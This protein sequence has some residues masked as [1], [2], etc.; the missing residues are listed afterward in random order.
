MIW[1]ISFI[2]L[3][4]FIIWYKMGFSGLVASYILGSIVWVFFPGYE[5]GF[6]G[7]IMTNIVFVFMVAVGSFFPRG[8]KGIAVAGVGG[9]LVGRN[10]AKL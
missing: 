8:A 1:F 2:L 9:Y 10:I 4:H 7:W 6:A 3:A 5:T